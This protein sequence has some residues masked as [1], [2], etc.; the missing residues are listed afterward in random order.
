VVEAE[1]R[2]VAVEGRPSTYSRMLMWATL[3]G[4]L[5]SRLSVY[6]TGNWDTATESQNNDAPPPRLG[7]S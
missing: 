5:V 4:A 3:E 2:S 1:T 7:R 6:C